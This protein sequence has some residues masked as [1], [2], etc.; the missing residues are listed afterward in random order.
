MQE[1]CA[2]ILGILRALQIFVPLGMKNNDLNYLK[3]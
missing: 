1:K 3:Y 2:G